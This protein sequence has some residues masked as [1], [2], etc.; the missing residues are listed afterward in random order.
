MRVQVVDPSAYTPPYDRSLCAALARA[1]ADVELVTS[2]FLYG[3]VPPAEGYEVSE[4]FY[5]RSARRGLGAPAR[6]AFKLAE[7]FGDMARYRRHAA[8]ADV[9]HYQ[10]LT[11]PGLDWMLLPPRAG[12]NHTGSASRRSPRPPQVFTAHDRP[13]TGRA[14]RHPHRELSRADGGVAAGLRARHRQAQ[15]QAV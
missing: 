12:D 5:R 10:W 7:H 15:D 1:G 14:D 11:M 9:V 13:L 4:S 8:E 3:P 6:R 2:R